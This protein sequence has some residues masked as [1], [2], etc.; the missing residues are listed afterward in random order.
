MPLALV[1]SET[2]DI[3]QNWSQTI[4]MAQ[5]GETALSE[6]WVL[7]EGGDRH[8]TL[9]AEAMGQATPHFTCRDGRPLYA[10]FCAT[11]LELAPCTESAMGRELCVSSALYR[12]GRTRT[13]SEHTFELD[14]KPVARLKMMSA[15]VGHD[16]TRRNTAIVRKTPSA[17]MDL[18]VPDMD[19]AQFCNFALSD[20]RS[21]R[22]ED[23]QTELPQIRL[24]PCPANDFNAVGLLYFPNY[25]SL[26]NRGLWEALGETNLP[27]K[28]RVLY[29]GNIDRGDPVDL[30]INR[31]SRDRLQWTLIRHDKS[32][33]AKGTDTGFSKQVD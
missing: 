19:L 32:V 26:A 33:L 22:T 16:E 21:I 14:G 17:H 13:A 10:A 18:P 2:L 5:L 6:Q 4:G 20:M 9:L 28:R 12:V 29:L 3:R 27:A 7:R 31:L 1:H 24:T 30:Q 23:L 11:E 25:S 15:F 8:W